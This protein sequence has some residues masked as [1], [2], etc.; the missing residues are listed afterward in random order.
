MGNQECVIGMGDHI[1]DRVTDADDV[2]GGLG[3]AQ[4]IPC[5]SGSGGS[6]KRRG[7]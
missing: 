3:H 1:D 7:V 4:R 5:R 2:K 6:R